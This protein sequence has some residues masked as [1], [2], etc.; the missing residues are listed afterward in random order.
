MLS[1][2]HT[3]AAVGFILMINTEVCALVSPTSPSYYSESGLPFDIT[4]PQPVD[5]SARLS[6]LARGG[7]A[8]SNSALNIFR[9]MMMM[10]TSVTVTPLEVVVK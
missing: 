9:P 3:R 2:A 7:L 1:R 8:S 4:L 10:I 6:R 5:T